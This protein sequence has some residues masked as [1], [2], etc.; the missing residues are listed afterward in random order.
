M[1]TKTKNWLGVIA[2]ILVIILGIL[3]SSCNKIY[4]YKKP[5][6][7]TSKSIHF[8]ACDIYYSYSCTDQHGNIMF[9]DDFTS[10]NIGDTIK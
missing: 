8:E 1:K 10:Y 6:I 4:N 3:A 2:I 5:F 9:F 7:I